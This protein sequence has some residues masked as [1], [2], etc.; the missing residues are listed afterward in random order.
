MRGAA[1]LTR[2]TGRWGID[3][4]FANSLRSER[5]RDAPAGAYPQLL[6]PA[7]SLVHVEIVLVSGKSS[8]GS[9][10]E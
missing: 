5:S 1:L 3:I 2:R 7:G 4:R 8:E 9:T 10:V 6:T